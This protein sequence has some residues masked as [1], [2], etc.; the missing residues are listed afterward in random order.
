MPQEVR[1]ANRVSSNP[2]RREALRL[3]WMSDANSAH[4]E[5]WIRELTERGHEVLLFSLVQPRDGRF[6]EMPGVR[7]E[8]AGIAT[9]IAYATDG[10]FRKLA[11]FRSIPLIRKLSR[12]YRPHLTHAHYASS[13][14]V[15]A[16]LAGLRP[17]IVSVW[18]A[19]IYR[20]AAR[21]SVHRAVISWAIRSADTVLSTSWTM[22]DRALELCRRRIE[23]V[24]FGIDTERFAP[25]QRS[26]YKGAGITIGAV[27]SLEH[28]YGIDYL[29]R[30]FALLRLRN[31]ALDLRLLIAGSG[32]QREALQ[33]LSVELGL[34]DITQFTGFVPYSDVHKMHQRLDIAVYPSIE[35]SESFG[36][37]VIESQSCGLPVI[38]SRIGGLPEVV[39]EGVTAIVTEPRDV[40]SLTAA[41]QLM[42]DDRSSAEKMGRAGRLRVARMYDLK[43]CAAQLERHYD[44]FLLPA[45]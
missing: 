25:V 1:L 32:S 18:G 17:R 21:S 3:F 19:D 29:L 38:V 9:D 13:Y 33:Q 26:D 23:V 43:V 36:V 30:A 24:P 35:H 8:T 12:S 40:D 37:S 27:K 6:T 5:R 11:Y 15:L 4:T 10:S 44:Q 20:T 14:G 42:I 22:R 31:P 39:E 28:K 41:M 2:R 7:V 45:S 16:A 34:E